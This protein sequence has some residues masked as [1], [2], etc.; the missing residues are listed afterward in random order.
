MLKFFAIPLEQVQQS[1]YIQLKEITIR[2]TSYSSLFE[3]DEN[4]KDYGLTLFLN[5]IESLQQHKILFPCKDMV[6]QY[7]ETVVYAYVIVDYTFSVSILINAIVNNDNIS[8]K[9]NIIY[10]TNN[11]RLLTS[12]DVIC[13]IVKSTIISYEYTIANQISTNI[14]E[15]NTYKCCGG[16]IDILTSEKL[17]IMNENKDYVTTNFPCLFPKV[18][19]AFDTKDEDLLLECSNEYKQ[20]IDENKILKNENNKLLDQYETL[21]NKFNKLSSNLHKIQNIVNDE[22]CFL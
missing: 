7:N 22:N 20:I 6:L 15:F 10:V 9:L 8:I 18:Y 1:P 19:K 13:N 21:L 12:T 16:A 11:S 4:I 3:I 14:I 17:N 2:N 5:Q